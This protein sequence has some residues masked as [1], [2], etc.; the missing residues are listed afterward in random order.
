[1]NKLMA[2]GSAAI[3]SAAFGGKRGSKNKDKIFDGARPVTWFDFYFN[4]PPWP[5][6]IPVKI[7]QIQ[8]DMIEAMVVV[9]EAAGQMGVSWHEIFTEKFWDSWIAEIART[10]P[11][12]PKTEA[13]QR[14]AL[15]ALHSFALMTN[16]GGKGGMLRLMFEWYRHGSNIIVLGANMQ[17]LFEHTSLENL[18]VANLKMPFEALYIALPGFDGEIYD[19]ESGMHEIRGVSLYRQGLSPHPSFGEIGFGIWGKP[20]L[21]PHGWDDTFSF[22]AIPNDPKLDLE[23]YLHDTFQKKVTHH[24]LASGKIETVHPQESLD[25]IAKALR[26]AFNLLIYWGSIENN[27]IDI[28]HPTTA[29]DLA[30]LKELKRR[31]SEARTKKRTRG[32]DATINQEANQVRR[33]GSW[34]YI[35]KSDKEFTEPGEPRGALGYRRKAPV[36]HI[37]KGHYRTYF[38]G[39]PNE[40]I[41]LIPPMLVGSRIAPRYWKSKLDDMRRATT[42]DPGEQS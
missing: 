28:V 29:A 34:F 20:K 4:P 25:G 15:Q 41:V 37:R 39:L 7:R 18:D 32:L 36:L 22:G 10:N 5:V 26:I 14:S 12:G 11:P 1:M 31:R 13:K 3:L 19:P 33:N 30:R 6:P 35:E 24:S 38:R 17:A 16:Q 8:K 27:K 9:I 23:R 42:V 21:S 40:K 2:V